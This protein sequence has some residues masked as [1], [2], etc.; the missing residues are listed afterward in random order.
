MFNFY[1]IQFFTKDNFQVGKWNSRWAPIGATTTIKAI[2]KLVR[3]LQEEGF[4]P[5]EY[6]IGEVE[7]EEED[8]DPYDH[9][10]ILL[11]E[12]GTIAPYGDG[13]WTDD[14]ESDF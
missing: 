11:W 4:S 6:K 8:F 13:N 3:I 9:G 2:Q 7:I 5:G 12:E 14:D 1:N 10:G